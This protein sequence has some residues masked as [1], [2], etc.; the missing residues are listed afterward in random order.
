[1]TSHLE[2]PTSAAS[3]TRPARMNGVREFSYRSPERAWPVHAKL[4][5]T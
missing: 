3:R 4:P 1:M 2:P 5:I